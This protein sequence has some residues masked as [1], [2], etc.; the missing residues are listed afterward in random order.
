MEIKTFRRHRCGFYRTSIMP[1]HILTIVD[2]KDRTAYGFD[3]PLM[4]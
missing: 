2:A 3:A 4:G 1:I